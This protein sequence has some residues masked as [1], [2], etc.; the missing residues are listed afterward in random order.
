MP[1][2]DRLR[3]VGPRQTH[4]DAERTLGQMLEASDLAPTP[5]ITMRDMLQTIKPGQRL[6]VHGHGRDEPIIVTVIM[7]ASNR[8]SY[9]PEGG[10]PVTYSYGDAGCC[11]YFLAN[12]EVAWNPTNYITS[13]TRR[14]PRRERRER[15]PA[16]ATPATTEPRGRGLDLT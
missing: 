7:I 8:F 4:G 16:E 11:P 15:T 14:Q 5:R 13:M 3:A 10:A 12:G 2:V 1:R 9:A 6:R